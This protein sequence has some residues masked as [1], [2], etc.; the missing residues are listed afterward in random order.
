MQE[1]FTK[2]METDFK[3]SLRSYITAKLVHP[4][5]ARLVSHTVG[6]IIFS[7]FMLHLINREAVILCL[8]ET[9]D[10]PKK[11]MNGQ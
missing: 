6:N 5:D 4:R 9:P 8:S 1:I 7:V 10:G 2:H 11:E 3:T